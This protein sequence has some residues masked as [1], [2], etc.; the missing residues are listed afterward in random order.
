MTK[1][2]VYGTLKRNH[3]ASLDEWD[4]K[5]KF[6]KEVQ[7]DG[8]DMYESGYPMSVPGEGEI[9]CE[10]WEVTEDCLVSLDNYE[11]TPYLFKRELITMKDG[12]QAFMYV[13]N[14]DILPY[15]FKNVNGV[16]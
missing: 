1:L 8:W 14:R 11:G 9:T 10:L 2:L 12:E 7:L 6:I 3:S 4:N 13:Y 5:N 16:F 15:F